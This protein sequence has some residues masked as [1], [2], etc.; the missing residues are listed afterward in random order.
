M[1]GQK[2]GHEHT[3][4]QKEAWYAAVSHSVC[5][6][7]VGEGWCSA[8]GNPHPSLCFIPLSLCSDLILPSPSLCL[9]VCLSVV[10]KMGIR[11]RLNKVGGCQWFSATAVK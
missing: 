2:Q 9:F 8:Q 11:R 1:A 7:D 10:R 4:T 3:E 5:L 6:A